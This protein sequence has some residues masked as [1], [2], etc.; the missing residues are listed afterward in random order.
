MYVFP[1][2]TVLTASMN[3]SLFYLPLS[4]VTYK[5][6]LLNEYEWM[7]EWM[8][9]WYAYGFVEKS[10]RYP[11]K[12]QDMS[13]AR[14]TGDWPERCHGDDGVPERGRDAA[15]LGAW[16][17]LLGIEYDRREDDDGHR[18]RE[19]QEAELTGTALQ[20]A[21]EDAESCRVTRELENTA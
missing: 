3:I 13:M 20:R 15:E 5:W 12:G 17:V 10:N 21:A 18:Q 9:E 11:L 2:S 8:N 16:N 14:V 6:F 19:D 1:Y 4:C 7:N